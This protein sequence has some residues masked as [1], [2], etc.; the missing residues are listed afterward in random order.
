MYGSDAYWNMH[1]LIALIQTHLSHCHQ[2]RWLEKCGR[3][4][5]RVLG[6]E[7]DSTARQ[8]AGQGGAILARLGPCVLAMIQP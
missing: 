7:V 5:C 1:K 4:E 3:V 6:E 2:T 8:K